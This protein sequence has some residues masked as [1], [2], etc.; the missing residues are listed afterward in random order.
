MDDEAWDSDYIMDCCT[1]LD[2]F[3]WAPSLLGKDTYLVKPLW[4]VFCS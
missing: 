2:S 4:L 3:L 1:T